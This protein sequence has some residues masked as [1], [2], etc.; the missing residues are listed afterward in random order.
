MFY[1]YLIINCW[2]ILYL[3]GFIGGV[4]GVLLNVCYWFV[5]LTRLFFLL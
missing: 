4:G 2:F 3:G 1:S 5:N